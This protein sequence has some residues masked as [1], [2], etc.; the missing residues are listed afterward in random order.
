MRGQQENKECTPAEGVGFESCLSHR[1]PYVEYLYSVYLYNV[2][3]LSW[4]AWVYTRVEKSSLGFLSKAEP[5][6]I[7]TPVCK[8]SALTTT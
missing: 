8:P 4:V 5:N 7:D 3:D 6:V 1:K 2:F